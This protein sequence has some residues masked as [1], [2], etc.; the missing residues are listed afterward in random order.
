MKREVVAMGQEPEE[1]PATRRDFFDVYKVAIAD[2]HAS[3]DLGQ[4][5]DS[6]YLTILTLLMTADAYELATSQYNVWAPTFATFGVAVIGIA[7]TSRWRQGAGN[8]YQIIKSRYTWLREAE[9]SDKHPEM[10]GVGADIFTYEYET[11]YLPQ[12]KG[13]SQRSPLQDFGSSIFYN[14]T[15]YLQT[16][17]M[18]IFAAVPV[19]IGAVTYLNLN[20]TL[21]QAIQRAIP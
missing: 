1:R 11:V 20:P 6:F 16:L 9:N 3:K 8:L 13:S 14:R 19:I 7:V 2:L 15:I 17:C 12:K 21:S 4:K 10:V 5:I 18:M